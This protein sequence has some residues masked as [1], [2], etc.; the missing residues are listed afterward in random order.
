MK[1]DE[2]FFRGYGNLELFYQHWQ[3]VGMPRA[4]LVIVHGVGEHS[5]RYMNVVTALTAHRYAVYGYDQ[6]GHGRS[7]GQRVHINRWTE[8]RDDLH[9]FLGSI[10]QQEPARPIFLY[11][12]SMGALVVMDYILHHP[13]GLQGAILSGAPIEPAGVAKPYLVALARALSGILPRFS[14]NLGLDITALSRDPQVVK[15]YEADP[16]TCRVVTVRWGTESLD[17]VTWVKAHLAET[18]LPTLLLHGEADRLDLAA[19]TQHIFR[20]ITHPDK[21]MHIYPGGYHEPHNDLDHEQVIRNITEWLDQ[22][23]EGS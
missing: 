11:G 2:S 8:Y 21:T 15:A 7:P 6:R 17:A 13:Q 18:A 5:G 14:V 3:P 10:R 20:T 16:L 9:A 23:T 12:H 22:H 19:G 4:V 1:H